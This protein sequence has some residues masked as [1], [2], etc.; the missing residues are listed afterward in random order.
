MQKIQKK[1]NQGEKDLNILKEKKTCF[2]M[3]VGFSRI[4]IVCFVVRVCMRYCAS[5]GQ[6]MCMSENSFIHSNQ[7]NHCCNEK[8][9]GFLYYPAE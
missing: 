6:D 9:K 1:K 3:L 2:G 7:A 4:V 5:V 8:N